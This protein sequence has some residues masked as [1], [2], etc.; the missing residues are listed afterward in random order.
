MKPRVDSY[1]IYVSWGIIEMDCGEYEMCYR[2]VG[3]RYDW[4]NGAWCA[5]WIVLCLIV[6]D[7][8]RGCMRRYRRH[9]M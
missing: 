6:Y 2:D 9:L 4:E 5:I 7:N 3:L 1:K 8:S